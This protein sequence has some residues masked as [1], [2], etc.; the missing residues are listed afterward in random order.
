MW[1][2]SFLFSGSL[3]SKS[4]FLCSFVFSLPVWFLPPKEMFCIQFI[5]CYNH[6]LS[7]RGL[8]V[9]VLIN[10]SYYTSLLFLFQFM[11]SIIFFKSTYFMHNGFICKFSWSLFTL[12]SKESRHLLKRAKYFFFNLF[13]LIYLFLSRK[14]FL[15]SVWILF[16]FFLHFKI[17]LVPFF[18]SLN[19][20]QDWK[21]TFDYRHFYIRAEN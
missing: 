9:T 18:L 19:I 8:L 15:S 2:V 10:N 14:F 11:E 16:N 3:V 12:V 21:S 1:F 4:F 7:S 13:N 20:I 17:F 6:F 5:V